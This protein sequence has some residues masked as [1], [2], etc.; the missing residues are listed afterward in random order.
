MPP[1]PQQVL[2]DPG[3]YR[4]PLAVQEEILSAL[5]PQFSAL[6]PEDRQ[7]TLLHLSS[8]NMQKEVDTSGQTGGSLLGSLGQL[9]EGAGRVIRGESM[10]PKAQ[11]SAIEKFSLSTVPDKILSGLGNVP[12]AAIGMITAP[13]DAYQTLRGTP[14]T[15]EQKLAMLQRTQKEGIGP[16]LKEGFTKALP[17]LK[18]Y[19]EGAASGLTWGTLDRLLTPPVSKEQAAARVLGQYTTGILSG[20]SAYD[21]AK[22]VM[23][24]A[25][26]RLAVPP[27]MSAAPGLAEGDPGKAIEGAAT[28]VGMAGLGELAGRAVAPAFQKLNQERQMQRAQ[29]QEMGGAPGIMKSYL[30]NQTEATIPSDLIGM[31]GT[32]TGPISIRRGAN[33]LSEHATIAEEATRQQSAAMHDQ[34][35]RVAP[36]TATVSDPS[37]VALANIL[38][39]TDPAV[40]TTAMKK[41]AAIGNRIQTE[42]GAGAYD[43]S[44]FAGYGQAAR[45]AIAATMGDI[46]EQG[47]T[48]ERLTKTYQNLGAITANDR[49]TQR[50]LAVAKDA[51]KADINKFQ[52]IAPE[53][54]SRWYKWN[55]FYSNEFGARF[56]ADSPLGALTKEKFGRATV[57]PEERLNAMG[58]ME[59]DHIENIYSSLKR[60]PQGGEAVDA[61]QASHLQR[62][63]EMVLDENGAPNPKKILAQIAEDPKDHAV[64]RQWQALLG[65]KRFA[66]M[67]ILADT[68]RDAGYT[69][70]DTTGRAALGP[71]EAFHV[72]RGG[73]MGVGG[74]PLA[75]LYHFTTAGIMRF[76]PQLFDKMVSTRV[77]AKLLAAGLME[78]PGTPRGQI[79]ADRVAK[80]AKD[81]GEPIDVTPKAEPLGLP[82]P[83]IPQGPP[84]GPLGIPPPGPG[85][86]PIAPISPLP[87]YGVGSQSPAAKSAR[88]IQEAALAEKAY[89]ES[90]QGK[91]DLARSLRA[92]Q[93]AAKG[94]YPD[95]DQLVQD[96]RNR[97]VGDNSFGPN[98]EEHTAL[99]DILRDKTAPAN[100]KDMARS[101]L[102]RHPAPTIPP[103]IPDEAIRARIKAVGN[104][105]LG[106]ASDEAAPLTKLAVEPHPADV[107]REKQ[108]AVA[109]AFQSNAPKTKENYTP[110]ELMNNITGSGKNKL[111][112]SPTDMTELKRA[113]KGT[114]FASKWFSDDIE[115]AQPGHDL[116]YAASKFS[117]HYGV[118][119]DYNAWKAVLDDAYSKYEPEERMT[120]IRRKG[121]QRTKAEAAEYR[122]LMAE[123]KK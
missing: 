120:Q 42:K 47:A 56:G 90:P 23:R 118:E 20:K 87:E 29:A 60:G 8:Q 27:L 46:A 30:K 108:K 85:N 63:N 57:P 17:Q 76:S 91:A 62:L 94:K 100:L 68:L 34:M 6:G 10:V 22:T 89:R 64:T 65:P 104:E 114:D 51:V 19:A 77:G 73:L 92:K 111:Y 99:T 75:S 7:S 97:F 123:R 105:V 66:G 37:S 121:R 11:P 2:S 122:R 95:T 103:L 107:I 36:K 24:P 45:D 113:Y 39:D 31:P 35:L 80:M 40:Q 4:N 15:D 83:T 3:F 86:R 9:P 16:G 102:A 81:L 59:P 52:G 32:E 48:F 109:K 55:Q 93:A 82:Q 5:D 18:G 115:Q 38:Q 70:V 71:M 28:G 41:I 21:A 106:P 117:E 1:T 79:V 58:Q 116:D 12:A 67:K 49:P 13:I 44:Q 14:L 98:L 78:E 61:V 112:V 119:N 88:A 69:G 101:V 72:V 33:I 74:N 50:L 84:P 25:L 26:A 96:L 43:A 54:V 110:I 53:A